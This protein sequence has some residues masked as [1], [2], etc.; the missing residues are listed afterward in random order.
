MSANFALGGIPNKHGLTLMT[1]PA[2]STSQLPHSSAIRHVQDIR[3]HR[4]HVSIVH[5]KASS[6][7]AFPLSVLLASH[8]C[9]GTFLAACV[10]TLYALFLGAKHGLAAM[11]E[12]MDPHPDLLFHSNGVIL[13]RRCPFTNF[14]GHVVL[15][16]KSTSLFFL[17]LV[18]LRGRHCRF[19]LYRG[20][21]RLLIFGI[22]FGGHR[23][24]HCGR[25][26]RSGCLCRWLC[27]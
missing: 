14:K 24:S 6:N 1:D 20:D 25:C 12:T 23:R 4:A 18:I 7:V 8:L 26:R 16:E 21:G 2:R 27:W 3:L 22:V 11:A 5:H 13:E 10:T 17:E 15:C 9:S 19:G